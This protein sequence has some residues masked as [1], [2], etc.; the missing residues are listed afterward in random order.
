MTKELIKTLLDHEFY[1]KYQHVLTEDLFADSIAKDLF[2]LLKEHYT[3]NKESLTLEELKALYV[4]SNP[5]IT[6]SWRHNLNKAFEELESIEL[7]SAVKEKILKNAINQAKWTEVSLL[8]LSGAENHIVDIGAINKL[9]EE[10]SGNNVE[11][12]VEYVTTDIHSLLEQRKLTYKYQM[13]LIGLR[14]AIEG[15]GPEVFGIIAGRPNS[16]KTA[17]VVSLVYHPEGLLAQGAKVHYIANEES[18]HR[19][20]LRG[21]SCYSGLTLDEIKQDINKAQKLIEPIKANLFLHNNVDMTLGQLEGYIK[22][23]KGNIDVLILDQIDKIKM[24]GTYNRNDEKIKDLYVNMRELA[25]RYGICILGVCQASGEAEGK[26]SYGF[27]LLEGSKTA[28]AAELDLC[29]TIGKSSFQQTNG[30][31]DGLRQAN[32]VK[33]KLGKETAVKYILN[34][35]LSRIQ[36]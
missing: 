29:I 34:H 30:V 6:N 28:K 36:D 12:E 8:A 14:D 19:T 4:S 9:L 18:A 1:A 5:T 7:S 33:N 35:N 26:L 23:N 15:I 11:Q 32:I 27:D 25:K 17:F 16:G 10:I 22:R 20:Q 21:F 3:E 2:G 31:D 13:P 24:R